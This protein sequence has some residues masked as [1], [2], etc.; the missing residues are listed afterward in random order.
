MVHR[1]DI[2][3][4]S[5]GQTRRGNDGMCCHA[6]NGAL[7]ENNPSPVS[8]SSDKSCYRLVVSAVPADR[9]IYLEPL[10]L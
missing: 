9:A 6:P 2:A 3:G 1:T 7:L 10:S 8:C 5:I 4:G